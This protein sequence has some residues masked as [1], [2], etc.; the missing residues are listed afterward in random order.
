M[1]DATDKENPAG[2]GRGGENKQQ[3]QHLAID[4]ITKPNDVF[5][6]WTAPICTGVGVKHS[7]GPGKDYATTTLAQIAQRADKPASVDKTEMSWVIPSTLHASDARDKEAQKARGRFVAIALDIDSGNVGLG[8]LRTALIVAIGEKAPALIYSTK[9]AT[10][11][12][13]RWRVFIP[14]AKPTDAAGYQATAEALSKTIASAGV[15]AGG[16]S[17]RFGQIWFLPNRGEYYK[18]ALIGDVSD[19]GSFLVPSIPTPPEPKPAPKPEVRTGPYISAPESVIAAFNEA[20]D[21]ASVMASY[22][23]TH[24]AGPHWRSPLQTSESFAT[25]VQECGRRWVS[26]SESDRGAGLGRESADGSVTCGDAFDLFAFF[27]HGN[28]RTK[29]IKDAVRLLGLDTYSPASAVAYN[30]F[31][32]ATYQPIEPA[33]QRLGDAPGP[34][35]VPEPVFASAALLASAQSSPPL[36]V[37]DLFYSDVGHMAAPGGVGKTTLLCHIGVCVATGRRCLGARV[38]MPGRFIYVTGEDDA[39][40]IWYRVREC[41]KAL[42]LSEAETAMVYANFAVIEASRLPMKLTEETPQGILPAPAVEDLIAR[43]K[44]LTPRITVID[45]LVSFS[46]GES[47]P[48]DS[49]QGMILACRQIRAAVGGCVY[50]VAHTSKVAG[51]NQNTDQY[52]SRG[53]S[54]IADGSRMVHIATAMDATQWVKETGEVLAEG[55]TAIKLTIAKNS[56]GRKPEPFLIHRKGFEFRAVQAQRPPSKEEQASEDALTVLAFMKDKAYE[57]LFYSKQ[58]L[59]ALHSLIGVPKHR[60]TVALA[61]LQADGRIVLEKAQGQRGQGCIWRPC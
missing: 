4:N 16:E 3:I 32:G 15:V 56:Y 25:Q 6:A 57:G 21:L 48:N 14:L 9:S 29:A 23:Y 50:M 30:P 18:W 59:T 53:G 19:P 42:E 44:D 51:Q 38:F 8:D 58:D 37:E 7:N 2:L 1:I 11:S 34:L 55:C 20:H 36:I 12:N 43:I 28:D 10:P 49:A 27:V 45:P 61:T 46:V 47:K 35:R 24:G 26:L 41:M 17:S 39:E 40:I 31:T 33:F 60:T 13:K 22:G 5:N 52:A 54:A